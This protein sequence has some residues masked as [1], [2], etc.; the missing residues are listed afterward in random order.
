MKNDSTHHYSNIAGC[1]SPWR[2]LAGKR[3]EKNRSIWKKIQQTV[4]EYSIKG[5][6]DF[7]LGQSKGLMIFLILAPGKHFETLETEDM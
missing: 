2:F 3:M 5:K 4:F 7:R 1:K 6:D